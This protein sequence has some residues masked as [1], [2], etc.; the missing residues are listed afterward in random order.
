MHHRSGAK[1]AHAFY[2]H[3][4]GRLATSIS[5]RPPTL[6]ATILRAAMS[7][8]IP[9]SLY[10]VMC[11]ASLIVVIRVAASSV[12]AAPERCSNSVSRLLSTNV[13]AVSRSTFA[14]TAAMRVSSA[15]AL[16]GECCAAADMPTV[17]H[18]AI[19][20]CGYYWGRRIANSLP[21]R[22]R[23]ATNHCPQLMASA[24]RPFA[25]VNSRYRVAT[26]GRERAKSHC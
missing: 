16:C 7:L 5:H 14:S 12:F 8:R 25:R 9:L 15:L 19:D 6:R 2:S 23:V 1:C 26:G 20:R 10:P 18:N 22:Q 4:R 3:R 13:I 21:Q 11:A 17:Y 24:N